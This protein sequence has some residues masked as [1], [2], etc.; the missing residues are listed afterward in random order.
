M[1]YGRLFDMSGR[2]AI[3]IGGGNGIGRECALALSAYEGWLD[4]ETADLLDLVDATMTSL[5]RAFDG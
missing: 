2:H 3:V 1:D 4:D 5:R